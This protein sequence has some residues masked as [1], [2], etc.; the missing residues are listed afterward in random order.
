LVGLIEV[1]DAAPIGV[2]FGQIGK[3]YC[4]SR[5][6]YCEP[7]LWSFP[8]A[9]LQTPNGRRRSREGSV[10]APKGPGG[11]ILVGGLGD[12]HKNW[13]EH[14]RIAAEPVVRW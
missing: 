5:D 14:R 1:K 6:R 2:Q 12:N 10:R 9:R 13:R 3:S 4:A 7:G 8:L 11:I